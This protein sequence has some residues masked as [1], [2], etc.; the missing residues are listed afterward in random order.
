MWVDHCVRAS[1]PDAQ[2]VTPSTLKLDQEKATFA[3]VLLLRL[4]KI[5]AKLCT[6]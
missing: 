2:Y 5:A 3:G 4:V 1:P 6:C